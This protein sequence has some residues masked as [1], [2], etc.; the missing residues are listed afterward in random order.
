MVCTYVCEAQS[1]RNNFMV[2][3]HIRGLSTVTLWTVGID[4]QQYAMSA[5]DTFVI[6]HV[7]K[8]LI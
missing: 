3:E 5:G 7:T 4:M 6:S 8:V 1:Y 2:D